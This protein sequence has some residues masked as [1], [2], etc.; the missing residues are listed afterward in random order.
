VDQLKDNLKAL[1]N[2]AFTQDELS[3]IDEILDGATLE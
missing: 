3:L 1:E 2:L